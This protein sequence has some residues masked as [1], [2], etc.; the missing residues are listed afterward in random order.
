M[1]C[2]WNAVLCPPHQS[3]I[4]LRRLNNP[5]WTSISVPVNSCQDSRPVVFYFSMCLQFELLHGSSFK[6]L[7]LTILLKLCCSWRQSNARQWRHSTI[8]INNIH[9]YSCATRSVLSHFRL[10]SSL[11]FINNTPSEQLWHPNFCLIL[12]KNANRELSMFHTIWKA[13]D[14]IV[15]S[16]VATRIIWTAKF[17]TIGTSDFSV[18]CK[19]LGHLVTARCGP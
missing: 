15:N 11:C 8:M 18:S 9:N 16:I 2:Y 4:I 5:C 1:W 6:M 19:F 14:I 7:T 3:K 13:S 12:V 17:Y 10:R